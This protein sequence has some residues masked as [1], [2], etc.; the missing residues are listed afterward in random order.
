MH[1]RDEVLGSNSSWRTA[2]VAIVTVLALL[3]APFCGS[4]C[5]ASRGCSG[6]VATE[7]PEGGD[8]HH[9]AATASANGSQAGFFAATTCNSS[10]LAAATVSSSKTWNELQEARGTTL[11]LHV[12]AATHRFP[13]PLCTRGARWREAYGLAGTSDSVTQTNVLRI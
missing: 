3:V 2:S 10:D 1:Q 13:S 9:G 5:A 11:R 7:A 8:C 12:V 6:N 4:L